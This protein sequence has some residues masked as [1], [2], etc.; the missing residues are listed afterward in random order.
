MCKSNDDSIVDNNSKIFTTASNTFD[1]DVIC[2]VPYQDDGGEDA[3]QLCVLCQHDD[4]D[5][6]LR[7]MPSS[8]QKQEG[9]IIDDDDLQ[10]RPS[11]SPPPLPPH[12]PSSAFKRFG[13][14]FSGH[15]N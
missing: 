9:P 13:H 7:I 11:S 4:D 10:V 1:E 3:D 5:V 6:E 12:S 15:G 14:F 8:S 2:Q